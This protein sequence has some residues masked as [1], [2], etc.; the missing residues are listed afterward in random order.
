MWKVCFAALV[1]CMAAACSSASTCGTCNT[2][3]N[4]CRDPG[5]NGA[6]LCCS[7]NF[8]YYCATDNACHSDV[9]FSCPSGKVFC[10]SEWNC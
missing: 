1:L 2:G 5:G 3:N 8:P 9:F 4:Y 7:V 10:S 6:D